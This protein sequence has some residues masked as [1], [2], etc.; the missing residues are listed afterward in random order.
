MTQLMQPHEQLSHQLSKNTGTVLLKLEQNVKFSD[1]SLVLTHVVKNLF[2]VAN[3]R[4]VQTRPNLLY[5][6]YLNCLVI[7][8]YNHVKDLGVA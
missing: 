7:H 2:L 5:S 8:G 4:K 3:L 6:K 1:M